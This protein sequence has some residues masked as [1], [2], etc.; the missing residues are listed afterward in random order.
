MIISEIQKLISLNKYIKINIYLFLSFNF[1]VVVVLT[2]IYK[3][4][5]H[6]LEVVVHVLLDIK[7]KAN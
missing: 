3:Y 6:Y 2:S 5:N 4:C 7:D 1:A